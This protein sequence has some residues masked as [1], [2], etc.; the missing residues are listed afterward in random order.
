M[1]HPDENDNL[2]IRRRATHGEIEDSHRAD[3]GQES[4]GNSQSS[5]N[6]EVSS[7]TQ[8][9]RGSTSRS[10]ATSGS[11]DTTSSQDSSSSSSSQARGARQPHSFLPTDGI[12]R[13]DATG[14]DDLLHWLRKKQQ[15]HTDSENVLAAIAQ[16][17]HGYHPQDILRQRVARLAWQDVSRKRHR[18]GSV[19]KGALATVDRKKAKEEA[20][21]RDW[22]RHRYWAAN[23]ER[24]ARHVEGE[25]RTRGLP[26]PTSEHRSAWEPEPIVHS[27]MRHVA[28]RM[29]ERHVDAYR[30]KTWVHPNIR[31]VE[32]ARRKAAEDEKKSKE[33]EEE[34][35]RK[36]AEEA[37]RRQEESEGTRLL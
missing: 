12:G 8:A 14:F 24:D 3:P 19:K 9:T 7:T 6:H 25:M 36:E 35:R 13:L 28:D 2:R 31:A 27:S 32:E 20:L 33:A 21:I 10:K 15:V 34:N 26:I 22:A 4:Q 37:K 1:S 5:G 23:A 30:E 11:G 29:R 16:H 18:D 17:E